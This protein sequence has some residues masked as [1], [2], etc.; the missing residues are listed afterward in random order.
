MINTKISQDT[1]FEP[2][3]LARDDLLGEFV[4]LL[5]GVVTHP[6]EIPIDTQQGLR[7][8]VIHQGKY[9]RLGFAIL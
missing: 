2:S 9:L 7:R 1:L 6:A 4:A 5:I 8:K 3:V